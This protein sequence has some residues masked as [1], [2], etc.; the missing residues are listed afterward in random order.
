MEI[1]YIVVGGLAL[2]FAFW[3]GVISG[4]HTYQN[5][6]KPRLFNLLIDKVKDQYL[7][8]D[9]ENEEFMFQD[10]DEANGINRAKAWVDEDQIIIVSREHEPV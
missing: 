8:Y 1:V 2:L 7:F 3:R 9:M 10:S 5:E 6:N 4:Y